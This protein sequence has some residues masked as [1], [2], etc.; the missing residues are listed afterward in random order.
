MS[1]SISDVTHRPGSVELARLQEAHTT[2]IL[3]SARTAA[4]ATDPAPLSS[5]DATMPSVCP[6]SVIMKRRRAVLLSL[7]MPMTCRA[8][9]SQTVTSPAPLPPSDGRVTVF[10]AGS[11]E[12]GKAGDWQA[13]VQQALTD[14]GVLMLNPRREDWNPAWKPN[15]SD[16]NFRQQ[17]LWRAALW[18]PGRADRSS[19]GARPPTPPGRV[20]LARLS[21]LP[22]RGAARNSTRACRFAAHRL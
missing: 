13:Q 12:M 11:I 18:Q 21:H 20:E 2:S 7:I 19:A 4:T 14:D 16:A 22:L 6:Y 5:I 3:Q 10:L 9:A 15:A 1:G 8:A 17:A